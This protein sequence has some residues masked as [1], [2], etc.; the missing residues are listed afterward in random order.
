VGNASQ[1]P[2]AVGANPDSRKKRK[3]KMQPGKDLGLPDYVYPLFQ[4]NLGP[5]GTPAPF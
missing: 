5:T 1:L 2:D 4:G 3:A